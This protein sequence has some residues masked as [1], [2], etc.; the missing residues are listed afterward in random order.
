MT[1]RVPF[2]ADIR[3]VKQLGLYGGTFDPVHNGHLIL[4]REALEQLGLEQILFLPA[5]LSPHKLADKPTPGALRA[6]MLR[7]AI[8][9]ERSFALDECELQR[10]APSFTVDTVCDMQ[11]RNPEA[12]LFY[13]VGSDN[14]DRLHT[15][16]RFEDLC[17][18][19]TFVVLDR[20]NAGGD[21]A[22]YTLIR[23]QIDVS[24]TDIRNRVVTGRS[25]RYLVPPA[26]EELI[27]RHQLYREPLR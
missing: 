24:A 6:E 4:A 15:W 9:H 2:A 20:G 25:I 19:V 7:V 18:L 21:H 17:R 23:R 1:W 11:Q 27:N 12:R 5:A 3:T 22:D 8:E 26:V 10:P 16:R 13:L 14:L